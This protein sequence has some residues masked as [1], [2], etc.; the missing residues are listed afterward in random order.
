MA[1]STEIQEWVNGMKAV[2]YTD[3]AL[4]PMLDVMES[5]PEAANYVKRS[6]MA[7][8]E[9]SRQ[10]D[11]LKTKEAAAQAELT[12]S[13]EW[14]QTV[15]QWKTD[16]EQE[17]SKLQADQ[18]RLAAIQGRIAELKTKGYIDDTMLA[19]IEVPT[20]TVVP[21]AQQPNT[22]KYLTEDDFTK[23]AN[24]YGV[25]LSK[26]GARLQKL[27]RQHEQTFTKRAYD[28]ADYA[29]PE[30]DGE[31]LIDHIDKNG[32][33]LEGA[34]ET[35]YGVPQRK[36]ALDSKERDIEITRK[37]EEMY[38]KR[39]SGDI[40]AGKPVPF[41]PVDSNIRRIAGNVPEPI[42]NPGQKRFDRVNRAVAAL[43]TQR[44]A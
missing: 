37:A 16:K 5:K 26:F 23:K 38:Q 21:P 41:K 22:A 30:F 15:S 20:S 12:K 17:F 44:T 24:G 42:Q 6:V 31:K 1:L 33:N 25:N 18:G 3:E 29:A 27:S 34:W 28:P 32:G 2:G 7:P 43:E 9:F 36:Q 8:S 35:I 14:F 10:L 4:K 39:V 13:T 11:T 40:Q 19:G